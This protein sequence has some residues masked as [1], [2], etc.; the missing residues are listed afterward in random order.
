VL[1]AT[2]TVT[3]TKKARNPKKRLLGAGDIASFLA[4]VGRCTHSTN[5]LTIL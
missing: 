5:E 2:A 1:W 4:L 3:E